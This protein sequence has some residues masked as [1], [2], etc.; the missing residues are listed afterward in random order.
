MV[1]EEDHLRLHGNAL[2]IRLEDAYAD[3]EGLD[4]IWAVAAFA[5]H[6]EFAILP[7]AH[8]RRT[9]LRASVLIHLPGL[10]LTRKSEGVAGAGPG[11]LTFRLYGR[12]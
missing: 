11:G 9:G 2:G 4:A 3:L 8:Q 7:P 10:V 5:F 6:P 12:Q 1:N